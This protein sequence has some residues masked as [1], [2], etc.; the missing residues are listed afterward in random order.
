MVA[1]YHIARLTFI[2]TLLSFFWKIIYDGG[3]VFNKHSEWVPNDKLQ[4]IENE[5]QVSHADLFLLNAQQMSNDAA[6]SQIVLN[7]F[8]GDMGG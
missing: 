6:C 4:C 8:I 3:Y 5:N 1:T 2:L 7:R